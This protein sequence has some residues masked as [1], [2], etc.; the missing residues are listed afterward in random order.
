MEFHRWWEGNP[1]ERYWL[2]ITGRENLGEDVR[3]PRFDDSGYETW[4]YSLVEEVEDGDIVFHYEKG[5]RAIT[6]WSLAEGGFQ[7]RDIY[8]GTPRTTGPSGTSVEPYVREGL[9][10]GLRGPYYLDEPLSLEELRGAQ[11]K[12]AA[13]RDELIAKHGAPIYFPFQLRSDG[14]RAAQGYLAKMP[15]DL[16]DALPG[17]P[18]V[19]EDL[20]ASISSWAP[21][22]SSGPPGQPYRVVPNPPF[23]VERDPFSVDPAVVERA[24]KSHKD[25]Q[26]GL[27][28]FLG[29]R[30]LEPRTPEALDIPWDLLWQNGDD[31]WVAEVKSLTRSN[32][33]RQLRLGLGQL[34]IYRQRLLSVHDSVR[35]A[36]LVEWKP[37]DPDWHELCAQLG[38]ALLWPA[39]ISEETL[40]L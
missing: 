5:Q 29:E 1:L 39:V 20:P 35:P 26:N 28:G 40:G 16:V 13:V 17:L 2:E 37:I 15:A 36:L 10:H 34:L 19:I 4:T 33:E 12:V 9:W 22:K 11:S 7:D 21:V 3:A 38:I 32:E 30:G 6:S 24:L 31:T 25:L 23:Q 8:W 27:A 18:D 14:L